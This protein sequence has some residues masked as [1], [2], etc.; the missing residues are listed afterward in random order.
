MLTLL[1]PPKDSEEHS[2]A[3]HS[4]YSN[5]TVLF[6]AGNLPAQKRLRHL[7][8]SGWPC[9]SRV[10]PGDTRR[11]LPTPAALRF[12][13]KLEPPILGFNIQRQVGFCLGKHR[14]SPEITLL[15]SSA[16]LNADGFAFLDE[17][18]QSPSL[19]SS[20][21]LLTTDSGKRKPQNPFQRKLFFRIYP[22]DKY[23]GDSFLKYMFIFLKQA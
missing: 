12:R 18:P 10:A 20:Q 7:T 9:W 6:G 8:P 11:S 22:S 16:Q 15:F 3:A 4:C 14:L 5:I 2:L 21:A 23:I 13:I 17:R 1:R 19:L